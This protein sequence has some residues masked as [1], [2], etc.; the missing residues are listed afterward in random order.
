MCN[1]FWLIWCF[2]SK[3][4][5]SR[6]PSDRKSSQHSFDSFRRCWI[7]ED[8]FCYCCYK[9]KRYDRW[10]YTKIRKNTKTSLCSPTWCYWKDT[11]S[12]SHNKK[13]QNLIQYW[14]FTNFWTN[15]RFL[16]CWLTI[17]GEIGSCVCSH[18]WPSLNIEIGSWKFTKATADE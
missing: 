2:G 8:G 5:R 17:F 1:I 13:Y 15:Q 16:W 6:K 18:C 7:K 10:G 11:N 9:Q 4:I 14:L 12:Q 3:K